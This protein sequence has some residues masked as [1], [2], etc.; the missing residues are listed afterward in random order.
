MADALTLRKK[1]KAKKPVFTMQDSHKKGRLAAKWR[2]PRGIQSKMRL[3]IRGY[4]RGVS[5]GYGS[6]RSVRGTDAQGKTPVVVTNAHDLS[7]VDT[8]KESVVLSGKIGQRKR[9][10]L[11]EECTRKGITISNMKDPLQYVA[12][13][14]KALEEKRAAKDKERKEREKKAKEAAEKKAKK[15]A[16]KDAGIEKKVLSDEE[17]KEQE[18][19]EKDRL[20]TTMKQ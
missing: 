3:N 1:L 10:A 16:G 4:R 7:A 6:P 18:K 15:D 14:R 13:V 11:V 5:V 17:R 2:R 19:K 8:A 9:L 20:L 12:R